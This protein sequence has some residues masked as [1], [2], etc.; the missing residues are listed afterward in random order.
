MHVYKDV[1]TGK[2]C[3]D[4]VTTATK[5]KRSHS[6]TDNMNFCKVYKCGYI[7]SYYYK[8]YYCGSFPH[9]TVGILVN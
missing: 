7:V 2:P 4:R 9:C 8:V 3:G 5:I 1:G 6:S